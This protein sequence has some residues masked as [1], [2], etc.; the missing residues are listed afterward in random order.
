[1]QNLAFN[2]VVNLYYTNRQDESNPLTVV[3]LAYEYDVDNTDGG[4]EMWNAKDALYVDGITKFLNLTYE[5]SDNGQTYVQQLNRPVHASGRP[6]PSLPS[7]PA[8]YATPSGFS[9]DITKYLAVSDGSEAPVA[10][11]RMFLNVNPAVNGA[12]NGTV[13]AARSG[14]YYDQKLPDYSYNWVRDASLTMDVVQTLYSAATDVASKSEY[15]NILFEYAVA[16]AT[17]QVDPNLETGLGEPKFY[18]NNTIFSGPWG[19][20]QS[21]GPATAAITLMEFA[22]TYLANGGSKAKVGDLIYNTTSYPTTGHSPVLYDLL[23]VA[24]NWQEPTYDLWEEILGSQF[25]TQMVQR[26]ALVQGA[27]FATQMNDQDTASTLSTQVDAISSSIENFWDPNR[28]ILLYG[29]P[30]EPNEKTSFLD[31]AVLLGIVHGYAGDN[32]YGYTHDQVLS[33]AV[34]VSTSFIDVYPIA[35][36]TKSHQGEP[37]SP[38]VGRYPEDRFNGVKTGTKPIGNPWYLCTSTF[39]QFMY[40]ASSEY[41]A[42]GSISVTNTSK[43]FFDYFTPEAGLEV[44]SSYQSESKEFGQVIDS[45]NGWGDAFIRTV[46]YYTPNSGHLTEEINRDTGS[47]QGAADLTWS[48]ASLLTAALARAEVQRDEG[49][50]KDLANLGVAKNS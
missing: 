13:V 50:G 30:E 29:Y 2:K 42:A 22:T 18:L 37:L 5:D 44:G 32:F 8:P 35:N 28:E 26:R 41:T 38:P 7:P 23:Y 15:E 16:R 20:P 17:E 47:P 46:Q 31:T 19:R 36:K 4:W 24:S 40:S 3:A 25:Y 45:L 33:T 49:Y 48:Y 12:V 9:D 27:K 10:H 6:E 21:D 14:P 34:R 11:Q 39:A 1:M 43:P